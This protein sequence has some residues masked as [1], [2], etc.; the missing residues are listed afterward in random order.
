MSALLFRDLEHPTGS[1]PSELS[2]LIRLINNLQQLCA[3]RRARH[4]FDSLADTPV[5]LE[6]LSSLA[7]TALSLLVSLFDSSDPITI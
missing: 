5:A 6:R 7:T 1:G 3:F 4:S 2:L